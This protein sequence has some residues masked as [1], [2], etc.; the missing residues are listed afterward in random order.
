MCTV[1]YRR[2]PAGVTLVMN[3]DERRGRAPEAPPAAHAGRCRWIGPADGETGGTWVGVSERGVVACLLNG[4]SAGD[5]AMLAASGIPSRGDIIPALLE[6]HPPDPEAWIGRLVET[7]RYPSF[8]LLV[9]GPTQSLRAEWRVN[10]GL[11]CTALPEDRWHLETSS[12]WRTTEV[13]DHRRRL[14]SRWLENG[15]TFDGPVATFNLIE[16]PDHREWSPLMTRCYSATRSITSIALDA[17]TG[18][19]ELTWWPRAVDRPVVPSRPAARLG[20][21]IEPGGTP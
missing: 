10:Q 5:L 1:V 20:I 15:A 16:E 17:D 3:R 18:R 11:G 8:T 7:T 6:S 2:S 13:V 21:E 4:Y 12:A 19:A 9:S 14:F